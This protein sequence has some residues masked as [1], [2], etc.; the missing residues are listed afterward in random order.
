ML[1]NLSGWRVFFHLDGPG[2]TW[3]NLDHAPVGG[4]YPVERWRAGQRIRDRF[5]IKF[6]A[7]YPPGLHTL[8]IG[9]WRPPSSANRRLPVSPADFQDG[10]DRLRVLS[11]AVE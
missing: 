5:R 9:F 6:S 2:G 8:H 1:G 10:Q 7:D 4:A 11:F 3:R